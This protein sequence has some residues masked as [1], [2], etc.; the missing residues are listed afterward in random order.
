MFDQ[1]GQ[2]K[3]GW[4]YVKVQTLSEN[5]GLGERAQR[6]AID[7]LVRIGVLEVEYMGL[8]KRR[9]FRIDF[10]RLMDVVAG[11]DIESRAQEPEPEPE[12][13]EPATLFDTDD[14]FEPPTREVPKRKSKAEM[15]RDAQEAKVTEVLDHLNEVTGSSYSTMRNDNRMNIRARLREGYTVEQCKEVID[16]KARKWLGTQF[17]DNLNPSTL[18]DKRKFDIYLQQPDAK[19]TRRRSE[20]DEAWD[21]GW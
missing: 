18:F 12:P 17:A 21:G 6:T 20:D 19:K 9:W 14:Y 5:T 11:V 3:D 15:A 8:P 7:D 2:L 4:F 16:K 10:H 1:Q 13:E